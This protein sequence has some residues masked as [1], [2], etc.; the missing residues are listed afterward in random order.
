M[1]TGI[2]G[3]IRPSDVAIT[4]MEVFYTYSADR[5]T[6]S[7][8][9]TR[10]DAEQIITELKLPDGDNLLEGMYNLTLPATIFNVLGIYTIY[11]RP[12]GIE[13]II[14]DCG[15]L[16]SLPT[17][18]GIVLNANSLDEN[19][20]S[21]NALQGYRIEYINS[22]GS[23][24][25]NTARY[26]VTSNKCIAV[27][28]NIGNTSQ[29]AVR[30]RFDDSG[31]LLFL[32]L[33]PAS[34]SNVKPNVKPFIGVPNQTILM[35]NTNFNPIAMEVELV[36]NDIDTVVNYVGN[37]QLKDV[38]NGILT[39]FDKDGNILNQFDL[40]EIK[41]DVGN[42]PLYE[43]KQKREVIDSSQTIENATENIN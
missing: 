36:E 16:S 41:D 10:I 9:T 2:Y 17:V 22:D 19:L 32:Q 27:T 38:D 24:L 43:V 21:N 37:N 34:A 31:N 4:D 18:K 13:T 25:R 33:T 1:A 30:Y 20:Q 29:T 8:T 14:V 12:K 26:V 35:Y 7:N 28:E 40:Y 11:I 6:P 42:V 3:N 15:V 23:K 5:E 39:N